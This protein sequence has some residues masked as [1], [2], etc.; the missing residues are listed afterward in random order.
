MVFGKLACF[1]SGSTSHQA[2]NWDGQ[3]DLRDRKIIR[4]AGIDGE[5]STDNSEAL[6]VRLGTFA[7]FSF[8]DELRIKLRIGASKII[9]G[10]RKKL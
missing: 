8:L 10:I 1:F 9:Y 5:G 6:E 7:C 3:G 4:R 2:Q